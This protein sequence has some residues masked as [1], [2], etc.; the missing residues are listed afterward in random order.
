MAAPPTRGLPLRPGDRIRPYK[1]A[2][3]RR[4]RPP[5][6][7][8]HDMP[9]HI[10]I[11]DDVVILSNFARLMNDPRHFDAGRDIDALLDQ[12]YRRFILE[13]ADLHELGPSAFGLL[14]TLIRR[15]EPTAAAPVLP[16]PPRPPRTHPPTTL[17]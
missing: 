4:P 10:R 13:L 15:I 7:S 14:T 2:P 3:G 6:G 11:D 5:A 16:H 9:I 1:E 8:P 17:S 12:G